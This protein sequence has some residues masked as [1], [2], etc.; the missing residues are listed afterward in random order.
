[1]RNDPGAVPHTVASLGEDDGS[2]QAELLGQWPRPQASY[3][4]EIMTTEYGG[5]KGSTAA[6][7]YQRMEQEV[8]KT[9]HK[10]QIM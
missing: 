7:N 6:T 5:R 9:S 3:G 8:T 1:M 4:H 2:A 10:C